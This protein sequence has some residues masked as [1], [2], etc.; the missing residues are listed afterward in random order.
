VLAGT[1]EAENVTPTIS[2]KFLFIV[3]KCILKKI[4]LIGSRVS[5]EI[6]AKAKMKPTS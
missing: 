4:Y 6:S 1:G 5:L 2:K 3:A